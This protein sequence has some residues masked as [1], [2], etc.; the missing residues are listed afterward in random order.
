MTDPVLAQY[1]AYPYPD[2]RPGDEKTRLVEG[3]PSHLREIDHYVF[4]GR[5]DFAQPFR[6]L[7]AGGGTGDGLVML[8]QQ[9]ADA[10]TPAEIV[11]LDL[12]AAARRIAEARAR[13]RGLA[14]IR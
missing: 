11:Y 8:A 14:G 12:S 7:V 4:G 2:R 9:L 5:R 1:E 6:A 10:R 13:T 3:S